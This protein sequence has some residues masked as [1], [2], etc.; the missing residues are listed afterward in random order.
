M[1]ELTFRAV[2]ELAPGPRWQALFAEASP[3]Y[4]AWFL[5]E[6]EA[7]RP[8]YGE[9][10]K[11]LERHLPELVPTYEKLVD[12]AG[13]GDRQA[14][15]LSLWCPTPFLSGCSQ[16]VWPAGEPLLVRNYDYS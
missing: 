8:T 11:M 5:R 13:G 2:S 10:R 1:T 16:A 15:L 7:R 6:G 12:L 3:A 9:S 14:R 4:E